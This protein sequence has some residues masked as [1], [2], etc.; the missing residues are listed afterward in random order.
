[1]PTAVVHSDH[2]LVRT[3]RVAAI[4]LGALAVLALAPAVAGA[5]VSFNVKGKWTCSNRGA[6]V[7]VAGARVELWHDIFSLWPDDKVGSVHT[8]SDGSFN[9]GVRAD[10]NFDL[11]VKLVLND[12]AGVKL[13]NWYSLSDWDTQ[14]D[15]TGSHA[16]TVNLGTWR[17]SKDNGA[18]TPK[19]AIWQ[20]GHN[21][22][23]DYKQVVGSRPPD[24]NYSISADFPC[25]GT[26]FTTTDTTRWPS[27]YQ[28]SQGSI[29]GGFAVNFHEFAHS[30]RHSF[31]GD[32][33]H[34][35]FDAARFL[36]P[37]TH[38]L[39]KETNAGFAFNEGWA[40]Y[41][42]N[43]P[44]VPPCGDGTNLNQ[45]GNVAT[46]LTGL[47]KCANRQTMVRVLR[48]NPGT[49]H[50]YPEFKAK[51]DAIVGRFGCIV[52][53]ITGVTTVEE[54]LSVTQLTSEVQK[55]IA[56]EKA[57][58]TKLSRQLSSAKTR[59]RRP[60]A[61]P[62]AR[63]CLTGIEKLIDPS[64]LSTQ[65]A[66]AKLVVARLQAGLAAAQQANFM[67]DLAQSSVYTSLAADRQ[68]FERANQLLAINGLK[69]SIKTV[70]SQSGF[71][72]AK[73]TSLFKTLNQRLSRLTNLRKRGVRTTS[74]LGTLLSAPEPPTDVVRRVK[75]T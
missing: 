38:T 2:S 9:F 14:T 64:G 74:D 42:A 70:T 66:Q 43:T 7:P 29:D 20:G 23:T 71:G 39:C 56:A 25:C 27:G 59:A 34:F 36:Y 26:P 68:S 52:A 35:L 1:M 19:C 22:Y 58:I 72:P 40:E 33:P 54:P 60:G 63:T 61:C 41:W 3:V 30:F 6:V 57:L 11:Y 24:A 46:A 73:S 18:G 4:L 5:S 31:D 16:G 37:Q 12:D 62:V 47:E 15:T 49:I 17:I 69:Q 21:A 10:S 32:F 67:P 55:Q 28:T 8:G 65:I 75:S 45:E 13:G 53:P 51:F 44:A 48:E 50:S